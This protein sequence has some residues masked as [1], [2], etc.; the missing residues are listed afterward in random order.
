ML[1]EMARIARES[2]AEYIL[3]VDSDMFIRSLDNFLSPLEEDSKQVI[4]FR[5]NDRMNYC[6]GVTYLLPSQGLYN[7]VKSFNTWLSNA[8]ENDPLF[9]EHCPEDWAITRCVAEINGYTM[10]QINNATDPH[11]WLLSPFVFKEIRSD[12]SISPLTLSRF[13]MYD[14]VNFGNRYELD[15]DNPREV[16]AN[17]MKKFADFDLTNSYE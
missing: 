5:L 13:Q 6:A 8:R 7:A 1:I 17:C 14:F 4:G 15:C 12:G 3:K 16:A 9:V 10:Y 11:N 2:K